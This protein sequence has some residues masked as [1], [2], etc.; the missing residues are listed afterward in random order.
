MKH[1]RTLLAD[2]MTADQEHLNRLKDWLTYHRKRQLV[3]IADQNS[4]LIKT[5]Q[6]RID[7][8]L[9]A[10]RIISLRLTT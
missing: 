1:D 3:A 10:Q 6:G 8:N 7:H 2:R 5:I 4:D 9:K